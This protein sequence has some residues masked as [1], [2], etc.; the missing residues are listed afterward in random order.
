TTSTI[1][2]TVDGSPVVGH[3]ASDDL[4]VEPVPVLTKEFLEDGTL[5]P[6]PVVNPGDDVVIRFT[7]TNTSTTSGATDIAFIDELTDGGPGTGFLPFPV[8]AVLPVSPCGGS[9][10]FVFPD[11]DRQGLSLTGGSLAA[12]GMAG[13]SCTFEVTLTIPADFAPGIYLNTTEEIT[14]VVDTCGDGCLEPVSGDPASDTLTVIAAPSLTKAFTDDPVAPGGTVTLEFTLANSPN[15]SGDATG[16]TFTDDLT[17]MGLAGLVATGLPL[18]EAC[19]PDGPGGDP[20]T[21]T[22]SG[23]AGDTLLTFMGGTLSP[24]ESCAFSV[25]LSV[26]AGAAPGS[27]TN[28]TSGVS[29]TVGGLAATAAPASDDLEVA[30]VTLTKEFIG[31]PVLPGDT[32]TLR[33]TLENVS[34]TD[35]A[36]SITFTDRLSDVLPGSPDLSVVTALPMAACGGTVSSA[37]FPIVFTGG[38]LMQGDPP[39]TFDITL[40]VPAG[41]ADGTYIN[42]TSG[43]TALLDDVL[44]VGD[45]ATDDLV[46]DSNLLSLI[47][48]F[49]DDPVAPG[50]TVTLEFTLT[51]LDPS[52]TITDIT[53]SDNFEDVVTGLAETSGMALLNECGGSAT[54]PTSNFIY[55]GGSLA[56]GAS[57]T[58]R[59]SLDVPGTTVAGIYPNTTSTV[60]GLAP[61]EVPVSGDAA[62]DDLEVL[63]LLL[64][65]KSFDGPTTATGMATLTFTITNPGANTASDISFSDDLDGVITGLIATSLPAL[66]CGAG[67]SLTGTTFLTFT[68]GELPP[69]GGM[70]SFDVDVLV[71]GT[72]TAGTF[73]N[74]TSDLFQSGLKVADPATADLIV[75]PPPTFAKAF[76]P[77]TIGT[78]T[79]STLTFTIDNSASALAASNLDFTDNLPAAVSVATPPNST[80]T[81]TGGTLTAAAA[82]GV[83]SYTGGS[84]GAGTTCTVQVDVTSST[85]GAHTNTTGDLTSSS[86]NSGTAEATLTTVLQ[87]GFGKLFTPNFIGSGGTSTLTFTI[88]NTSSTV[89]A[90]AL[91]FTDNL[92][93]AVAMATPSNASTTC[94]GGALTAVAGSGVIIYT[95]GTVGAGGTCTVD[96]DV[97]SS[98]VG[99]HVNTTGDLT[100]SLGSSGTATD[101]LNVVAVAFSKLFAPD[102]IGPGSTTLLQFDITNTSA[103]DLAENLA[104]TDVLPMGVVFATPSSAATDCTDGVLSAPDGG[105][106]IALSGA[107]LGASSSCTVTVNVTA[108]TPGVYDN[109][110]GD[111]TSTLGNSGPATATLEV[112]PA[113][114]GFSKS[115]VPSTIPP[116]G[117]ST[118]IFTI[119]YS[120]FGGQGG[121]QFVPFGAENLEFTDILPGGVVVGNPANETTD[122]LGGVFPPVITAVPGTDSIALF[123]GFVGAGSICTVEVDVTAAAV[124]LYENV[125]GE[126]FSGDDPPV[127]SG[128][129]TAT[130]DVPNAFL[131]KSFT[132]DP[133]P[134]GGTVTL[135]FTVNNPSRDFPATDIA[136]TDPIDPL[137]LLTG[138]VPGETLPKAA[139]GGTLDFAAGTLIFSGGMLPAGGSCVFEV[140]LG[141]PLAAPAGTYTNTTTAVT[142]TIDGAGVVGNTAADNLVVS[143]APLFTKEFIDDPVGAGGAVTLRFTITNTS[144][145][146]GLTDIEFTDD[147]NT[148]IP[149]LAANG[150][151]SGT[152]PSQTPVPLVDVCGVGSELNALVLVDIPPIF[153][154]DPTILVLTG[155]SLAPAGSMGDS[156]TFDVTL[157]VPM[158][159]PTGSYTNTTSEIDGVLADCPLGNPP[160]G[161]VCSTPV[162]GLPASDD[163]QVI[164][165]PEIS[166]DFIDDPVAPG[167]TVTLEFT[168]SYPAEAPAPATDITFTDDLGALVPALTGVTA[169][170]PASPD[171]PCGAGSSLVGSAGDT[172]LTFAGGTLAPGESCTFSVTLNVPV[173]ASAGPYLNQTSNIVATVSGMTT[174]GGQAEAELTVAGLTLTKQFTDDPVLAGATVTLEFAISNDGPDDFTDIAFSDD[175]DAVLPGLVASGLPLANACDPDP[176]DANPGTG[177]LSTPDGGMTIEFAGGSLLSGEFCV[178]S[179][180]LQVPPGTISGTYP[181]Q[182]SF[183]RATIVED[184]FFFPNAIDDLVVANE[185]LFLTKEFID[186]PTVPGGTVTLE[187]SF[188]T[189]G[190]AESASDLAFT[191]DLEAALS[192]LVAVPPFDTGSCGGS[193][194]GTS[195]LSYSGGSFTGGEC[196]FSVTLQVPVAVPFGTTITNTTSEVTGTITGLPVTGSPASDDL[197]IDFFSFTKYFDGLTKP[198][199]TPVLTFTIENLSTM[200]SITNLAFT[201]DLDLVIPGLV[202][203]SLPTDPCGLGSTISGTSLL[204]LSGG[205]LLPGGSCTFSVDLEVPADAPA[206][207][208][209]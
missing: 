91:D 102:A 143:A 160:G 159:V 115:F 13:D 107:R 101:T 117:T 169:N 72:A 145:D 151:V 94:I 209:L 172:L 197:M 124:G 119:D 42:T 164:G 14:A 174:V 84:V 122:C 128:F 171:P 136:F 54:L 125:S 67:S 81:C 4:F 96:V 166:K 18:A 98:T 140:L 204:A 77:S 79:V 34:P 20:G 113:L 45:P 22:L 165:A 163:L 123:S 83:I 23:S 135:E 187:F 129:A 97:T 2:A 141:V 176:M 207:T 11:T 66:P 180:T 152:P 178:F 17:G 71:P 206:G 208:F 194:T 109:L 44:F 161:E 92:P 139:C 48:E 183:F 65:T 181:N 9:I 61:P 200:D 192:G 1:T 93:A 162:T 157:D 184:E 100:S 75:E 70:C 32:V 121:P 68:G 88:D 38:S 156:C 158:G 148:A 118:L 202:A 69:M 86:G 106:T 24:G 110:S 30:G 43:F 60:S 175:L 105:T 167:D 12:A 55:T 150:L 203:T 147:L 103:T 57:C 78:G 58:I 62:S 87:P 46:V 173:S 82:T 170:L 47:K 104:F 36:T 25:T 52:E 127:S 85:L 56:G 137:G 99:S 130:L 131:I 177:T 40:Q 26:P 7:I 133:V 193:L 120:A 179:V 134:P 95:G 182:T 73:P 39:C 146:A 149:G 50:D 190:I 112:D 168:L 35:D 21:G 90:T 10:G 185:Q 76:A 89:D 5:T 205:N 80:T 126:L 191:D 196:S 142:A 53:F 31:D 188:S 41:A 74:T 132:D 155:G 29:A 28:T 37:P 195:V 201:D 27:H 111:L 144:P 199:G 19:D 186:D 51:N 3:M 15:A 154:A 63:N 198:T 64:F 8:T 6:D 108:A 153:I 59:L 114:P 138:L 33:F 49:T 16:I 189:L 116:G